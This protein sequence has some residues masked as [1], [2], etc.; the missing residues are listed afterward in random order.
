MFRTLP[1]AAV[2]VATFAAPAT[3]QPTKAVDLARIEMIDLDGRVYV[4][5]EWKTLTAEEAIRLL[6]KDLP[7]IDEKR[8]IVAIL[9]QK[10]GP[11][12]EAELD[13][14]AERL[15]D[16]LIADT[17]D[18]GDIRVTARL[19]LWS[20][21][22]RSG[23]DRRNGAAHP[24]SFDA[25]V[26]AYETVEAQGLLGPFSGGVTLFDLYQVGEDRGRAYVQSVF[27]TSEPPP[28]C[29][30]G[31]Y[32]VDPDDPRPFC[33]RGRHGSLHMTSA[34]CRAGRVLYSDEVYEK[35]ERQYRRVFDAGPHA[36][37]PLPVKGLS[38][39][40]ERW[41]NL[42]WDQIGAEK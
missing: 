11:R 27:E 14:L 19:A 23:D 37:G 16:I 38:E 22:R 6:T 24:G 32:L 15:A 33:K 26:R 1:A 2:A 12:P 41:W 29:Q 35:A 40:A 3:G 39:P 28:D 8:P 30:R 42:C 25:M 36:E 9:R 10:A 31:G 5:G 21:A 7:S 34:F 20:A 13:A 18:R 17:T 4:E